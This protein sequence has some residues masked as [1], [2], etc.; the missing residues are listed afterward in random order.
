[1]DQNEPSTTGIGLTAVALVC[2]LKPSPARSS[3]ELL[4]QQVLDRMK[5]DGVSGAIVRV[6]DHDRAPTST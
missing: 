5:S 6:V 1:M 2:S 3:S 4:A